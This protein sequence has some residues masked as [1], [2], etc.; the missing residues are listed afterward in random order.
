MAQRHARLSDE[1]LEILSRAVVGEG[2]FQ[3]LL[4][5]L[6]GSIT[7]RELIVDEDTLAMMSRYAESYG[8]GGW[9]E[10]LRRLVDGM[11]VVTPGVMHEGATVS[12]AVHGIGRIE[13]WRDAFPMAR[14]RFNAGTMK[15][16]KAELTLVNAAKPKPS[17]DVVWD[18]LRRHQGE[19]FR[20]ITGGDFTYVVESDK[21]V[22]SRTD[23]LFPKKQIAEAVSLMPIESTVP[24]QH[25]YGPSYLYAMLMDGRIRGKDW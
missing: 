3:T 18:R 24:L 22:P 23:W 19:V 10:R 13:F 7:G 6:Q 2:G 12:H 9:Q 21:V 11:T 8:V 1:D 16:P 14:V 20:Q 5:R 4:R 15:V 17:I 25:L